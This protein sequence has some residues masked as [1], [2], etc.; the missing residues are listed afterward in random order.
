MY[1]FELLKVFCLKTSKLCKLLDSFHLHVQLNPTISALN[2]IVLFWNMF[3]V[4][5]PNKLNCCIFFRWQQNILNPL[6][7]L[8]THPGNFFNQF[9]SRFK[10]IFISLFFSLHLLPLL[11]LSYKKH[12]TKPR[13]IKAKFFFSGRE[14]K[15]KSKPGKKFHVLEAFPLQG[16]LS[17]T[18]KWVCVSVWWMRINLKDFLL[19][20]KIFSCS[21]SFRMSSQG[22]VKPKTS[23]LFQKGNLV[24]FQK[25]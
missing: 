24:T 21:F 9:S 4:N 8:R 23:Y 7:H 6:H 15:L 20:E 11:L 19:F 12:H 5:V 13:N 17:C 10:T 22:W 18:Q 3:L 14:K 16:C 1:A 25:P 2:M